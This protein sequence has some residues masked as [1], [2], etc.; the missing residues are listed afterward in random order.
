MST[1][2]QNIRLFETK[3][4]VTREK[5][6]KDKIPLLSARIENVLKINNFNYKQLERGTFVRNMYERSHK[7]CI[8]SAQSGRI[9][10]A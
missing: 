8:H 10:G 3:G 9:A 7:H 6:T 5:K 1:L 4:D 2:S